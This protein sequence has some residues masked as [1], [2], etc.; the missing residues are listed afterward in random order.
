MFIRKLN[1]YIYILIDFKTKILIY[2]LILI[3]ILIN[4]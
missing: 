2:F 3:N 1:I 4:Y